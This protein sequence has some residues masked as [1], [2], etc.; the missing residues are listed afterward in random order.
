MKRKSILV[1]AGAV[2]IA[3]AAT[4]F[5]TGTEALLASVEPSYLDLL[6]WRMVGPSRGGRVVAVAGDPVNKQVFYFGATGGGVRK[7]DDG[8]LHWRNI[9]TRF[10]TTGSAGAL[11]PAPSNPNTLH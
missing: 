9:S 2:L 4:A 3:V 6:H 5:Q 7:T 10:V 1:L 11:A 8:G